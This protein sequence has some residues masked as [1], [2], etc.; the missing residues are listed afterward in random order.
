M[1]ETEMKAV[2]PL[3]TKVMDLRRDMGGRGGMMMGMRGGRPGRGGQEDTTT[4]TGLAK[5]QSELRALTES[6]SASSAAIKAKLLQYRTEREKIQQ[7]LTAAQASLIKVL[8][9]KQE[10]QL[11]LNGTLE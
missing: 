6:D 8:T 3:L 4:L 2:Q 11:V 1:T 7:Q 5:I 9:P 10:A